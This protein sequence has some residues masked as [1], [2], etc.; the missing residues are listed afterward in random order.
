MADDDIREAAAYETEPP[1]PARYFAAH[2]IERGAVRT[3]RDE[4]IGLC[5]VAHC[6]GYA[7]SNHSLQVAVDA[8]EGHRRREHPEVT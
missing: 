5:T 2:E 8:L 6:T 7:V 3:D 1:P 4:W